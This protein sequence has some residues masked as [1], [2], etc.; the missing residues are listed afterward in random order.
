MNAPLPSLATAGNRIVRKDTGEP[1]LLRGVNRSGLEYGVRAT[2]EEIRRI[3][4]EWKAGI[5]RIPF[6]QQWALDSEDYRRALDDI[7]RWAA[8]FGAYALLDLQWLRP[9]DDF[10]VNPNGSVQRIAPLPDF[11]SPR[12]WRSL[13]ERYREEPAVLFDIYNEPHGVPAEDWRHWARLLVN[14]IREVHPGSLIFV[15]GIDWGYDLRGVPFP[16]EN[17][18]WSTHVY[19]SKQPGWHA[20]FGRAATEVPV[21]AGEWGGTDH[22]LA[23]GR[24]LAAYLRSLEIGW[25]A[26]SWNDWP[27]L[28]REGNP[29]LFGELVRLE[30]HATPH[31]EERQSSS[32][33]E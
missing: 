25:T 30:L 16:G 13:A 8:E 18:V 1:V 17:L 3:V 10:G 19:P 29:T 31:R 9:D 2:R 22:D 21:F 4:E 14:T 7:V 26:W 12:L 5:I 20:A 32:F 27:H 24:S 11:N 15:S 33:S 6:T 28:R 23:W